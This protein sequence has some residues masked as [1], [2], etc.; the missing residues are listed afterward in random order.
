MTGREV[1]KSEKFVTIIISHAMEVVF[2]PE[3]MFLL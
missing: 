2:S 3:R 1:I